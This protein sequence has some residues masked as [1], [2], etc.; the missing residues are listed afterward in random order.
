[1]AGNRKLTDFFRATTTPR[2]SE[3]SNGSED[4]IIVAQN[5]DNNTKHSTGRAR[6][7]SKD[8]SSHH[9][10][11]KSSN[12]T[13]F[14][15]THMASSGYKPTI[16]KSKLIVR[17][18]D[19]EDTDSDS[20]LGGLGDFLNPHKAL[21][22]SVGDARDT[23]AS[24]PDRSSPVKC[25]RSRSNRRCQKTEAPPPAPGY[26]FSMASL[27]MQAEKDTASEAGTARARAALGLEYRHKSLLNS[28]DELNVEDSE[29]VETTD[30]IHKGLLAS[31][32]SEKGEEGDFQKVLSAMKRTEALNRDKPARP[33]PYPSGIPYVE[34]LSKRAWRSTIRL[35]PMTRHRIQLTGPA[36]PVTR[37]HS[38]LAG[39][40]GDMSTLGN[41]LPDKMNEWILDD[42]C[43][44]TRDD[45]IFA[46]RGQLKTII[47]SARWSYSPARIRQLF[48]N[49]GGS[50]EATRLRE[51]AHPIA[52]IPLEV[53][54]KLASLSSVVQ[55]LG[56][57]ARTIPVDT[58][59]YAICILVRLTIDKCVVEN[60]ELQARIEDAITFLVSS[61]AEEQREELLLKI[62]LTIVGFVT[63][64]PLRL[65]LLNCL[66]SHT[67]CLHLFRRRLA[68]V[69]FFNDASYLTRPEDD[70]LELPRITRELEKPEFRIYSNTDY[71]RIA[72]LISIL[73]VCIDNGT[74][75]SSFIDNDQE[76]AFDRDIDNL[77]RRLKSMFTRIVDTGASYMARTEAKEVLERVH[78]RLV[79]A[80][81][82]KERLKNSIFQSTPRSGIENG[83]RAQPTMAKF[84]SKGP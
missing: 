24:L 71:T 50:D 49:L 14:T 36:D 12:G 75:P 4:T 34:Q 3:K 73:D 33:A 9:S 37:Q 31:I 65:Q 19:S 26:K 58:K 82:T 16:R 8:R 46:Y 83:S 79:F 44:E 6:G 22:G 32:L 47:N 54:H 28:E 2:A 27:V 60:G 39:F 64:A 48:R 62:S 25:T 30:S 69:F 38:L 67:P 42:L 74:S 40:L 18:S 5:N 81:R 43:F 11:A 15:G 70:L 20:S 51:I 72:P 76:I 68:L 53:D 21:G 77:A 59:E 10:S 45:I 57:I 55:L 52:E 84:L 29:T 17:S 41:C 78:Y 80:V 1:M 35:A 56:E 13:A 66:P 7:L 61:I 23:R 63:Y